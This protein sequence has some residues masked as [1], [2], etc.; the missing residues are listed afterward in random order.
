MES[1]AIQNDELWRDAVELLND[2]IAH[3]QFYMVEM[4]YPIKIDSLT[5]YFMDDKDALFFIQ[6]KP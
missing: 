4:D 5:I 3:H 6:N 1:K 2:E